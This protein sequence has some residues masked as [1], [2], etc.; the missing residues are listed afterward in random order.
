MMYNQEIIKKHTN[1]LEVSKPVK[2]YTDGAYSQSKQ[3]GGYSF[4]VLEDETLTAFYAKPIEKSTN[5]RAE[6]LALIAAFRYIKNNRL[7][8]EVFSDSMYCIGTLTSN[9]SK[10]ANIDLWEV[11]TPL[12]DEVKHLIK[13]T[14][15]RGHKGIYGNEMAD[16]CAVMAGG[17]L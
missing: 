11:L 3:K 1:A 9:W 7:N 17:Y 14:H 16:I 13:L 4:V 2:I 6:M 15:I 5:Q 10:N 12:Y 8:C